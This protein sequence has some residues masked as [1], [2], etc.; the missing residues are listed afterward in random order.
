PDHKTEQTDDINDREL[1]NA[2]LP[3]RAEVRE[4]TDREE[5]EDEE[6]HAEGIGLAHRGGNLG[7]NVRR[8]A[9]NEVDADQRSRQKA[10]DEL[11][12]SLPDLRRLR[13]VPG[14][15]DVVGPDVTEDESPDADEDIDEDLHG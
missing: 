9:E 3:Q 7:G 6:D 14:G 2:L 11:R 10:E 1:A 5:R 4:H 15:I 12:E 8:G 13:L